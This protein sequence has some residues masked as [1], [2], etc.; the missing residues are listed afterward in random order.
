MRSATTK[1]SQGST[2]RESSAGT[3]VNSYSLPPK[4]PFQPPRTAPIPVQRGRENTDIGE[5][6][7]EMIEMERGSKCVCV[8]VCVCVCGKLSLF[9]VWLRLYKF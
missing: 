5:R 4:T 2:S 7:K 1:P 6:K 8:C 3:G 9:F